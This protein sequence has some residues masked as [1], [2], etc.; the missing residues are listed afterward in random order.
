[1][2]VFW[3]TCK[4]CGRPFPM[5]QFFP[6]AY[7]ITWEF[8]RIHRDGQQ[9]VFR[10][11]ASEIFTCYGKLPAISR[12]I[13]IRVTI[14]PVDRAYSRPNE[15]ERTNPITVVGVAVVGI[16]VIRTTWSAS[17]STGIACGSTFALRHLGTRTSSGLGCWCHRLGK[18]YIC[19]CKYKE[20]SNTQAKQCL[21]HNLV[22][23]ELGAKGKLRV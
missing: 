9:S 19:H 15:S 12:V 7:R 3:R 8:R 13:S 16:A 17:V 18:R 4:R 23:P 2:T 10:Q 20:R 14:P 1:M 5:W 21:F 22:S 6:R 11:T